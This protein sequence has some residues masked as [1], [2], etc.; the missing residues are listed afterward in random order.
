MIEY[1]S[2]NLT[3]ASLNKQIHRTRVAESWAVAVM[4]KTLTIQKCDGATDGWMDGSMDQP[5]RQGVESRDR[6]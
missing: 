2:A 6:E 4:Q 5:T 3:K 1:P